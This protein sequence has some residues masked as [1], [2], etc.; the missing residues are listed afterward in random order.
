MWLTHPT[1]RKH[2]NP[3]PVGRLDLREAFADHL[4]LCYCGAVTERCN[5]TNE[6]GACRRYREWEIAE[7]GY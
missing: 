6:C 3:K 4:R 1:I 2:R 5:R 7:Y